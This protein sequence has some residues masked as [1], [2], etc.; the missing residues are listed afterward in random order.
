MT[1]LLAMFMTLFSM[2]MP[3]RHVTKPGVCDNLSSLRAR[4]SC[5]AS[6]RPPRLGREVWDGSI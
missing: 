4:I 1:Y 6:Q 2:G 5:L 3:S